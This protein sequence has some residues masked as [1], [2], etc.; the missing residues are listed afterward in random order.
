MKDMMP[1][2]AKPIYR[3]PASPISE[4]PVDNI[5][6]RTGPGSAYAKALRSAYFLFQIEQSAT[7]KEAGDTE[8]MTTE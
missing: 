4:N 2:D 7:G 3:A 8:A 5:K 1:T 6:K